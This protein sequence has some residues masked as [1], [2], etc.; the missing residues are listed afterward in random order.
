LRSLCPLNPRL[1]Q[2]IVR[3]TRSAA[4][5]RAL[6][7]TLAAHLRPGDLICLY[8]ELGAGKTTLIQGLAE[9]LGVTDHVTSP[10]FTIIHEH[11]GPVRFYHVDLYRL[12]PAD[13]ADTGIEDL[14][15]TD[16]VVAVEWAER[17]P[18]DIRRDALDVE[19]EFADTNGDA[20]RITFR[21]RSAR[22][23]RMLT[24]LAEEPDVD[25]GA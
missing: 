10:S 11:Q 6:G 12:S 18:P 22:L 9:G 25:P 1:Q 15:G 3:L 23:A 20:R 17:L 8:G 24:P 5:T 2:E 21:A 14:I 16:A 7:R 13:F 19:I 4:E